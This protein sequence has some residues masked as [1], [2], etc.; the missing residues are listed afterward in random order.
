MHEVSMNTDTFTGFSPECFEFLKGLGK[1]N[2]KPWFEAH[3]E[4]YET[5]VLAP[6]RQMATYLS[7]PM[8]IIDPRLYVN[9][10]KIIS[11][12]YRDTRFSKN[13]S[14][15]K[16]NLWLT[17]KRPREDWAD[18]PAWFFEVS[19]TGYAYGMGFF[20]ASVRTMD[21]LRELIEDDPKKLLSVIGFMKKRPDLK[22][23]GELYKKPRPGECLEALRPWH[24]RKTLYLV[25]S[26]SVGKDGVS[27]KVLDEVMGAFADL[28]PL[29]HLL[30]KVKESV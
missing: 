22:L 12:I 14:P 2:A 19:Q 21:A 24:D 28:V 29:Y 15:Y 25:S 8:E 7:E 1:H 30:W 26:K 4:T 9:P 23:E 6:M 16:T 17:F 20:V 5:Q 10:A 18:T 11:R 13:K 3:R 27:A